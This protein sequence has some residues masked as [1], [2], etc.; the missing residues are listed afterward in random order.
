MDGHFDSLQSHSFAL[1][2]TYIYMTTCAY[3]KRKQISQPKQQKN[4]THY[5]LNYIYKQKY[6]FK[7][8]L[9]IGM[10]HKQNEHER[11]NKLPKLGLKYRE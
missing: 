5:P 11:L 3:I 6:S 10:H 7:L 8:L 4:S 2:Y 9:Y 1:S